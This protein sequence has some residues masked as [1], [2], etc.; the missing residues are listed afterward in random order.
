MYD[1]NDNDV[2]D[3]DRQALLSKMKPGTPKDPGAPR[4]SDPSG[5][6]RPN[7]TGASTPPTTGLAPGMTW[8]YNP[9]SGG[10]DQFNTDWLQSSGQMPNE[11]GQS[12]ATSGSSSAR[13]SYT[14]PMSMGM[15]KSPFS[16]FSSGSSVPDAPDQST[17]AKLMEQIAQ[18]NDPAERERQLLIMQMQRQQQQG[19]PNGVVR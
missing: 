13:S 9:T 18:I 5:M 1:L 10:W 16:G 14:P 15:L 12:G 3:L 19:V 6:A 2:D 8:V 4:T 11:S 17:Y 7:S